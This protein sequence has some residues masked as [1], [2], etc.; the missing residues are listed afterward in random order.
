MSAKKIEKRSRVG[1]FVK[2]VNMSHA[3]P[4]RYELDSM[5]FDYVNKDALA[6]ASKRKEVTNQARKTLKDG[7]KACKNTWFFAPLRF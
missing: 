3:M 4:T 7:Y 5:S 1:A 6:D 2:R